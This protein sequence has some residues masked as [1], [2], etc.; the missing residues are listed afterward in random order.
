[1]CNTNFCLVAEI[2]DQTRNS[3]PALAVETPMATAA[4]YILGAKIGKGN[5]SLIGLRQNL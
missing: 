1:M 3:V 2:S 4:A 5:A